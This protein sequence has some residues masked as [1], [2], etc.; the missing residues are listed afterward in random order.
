MGAVE[1]RRVTRRYETG[2]EAL[3]D[4]SLRI[5]AGSMAFL[6]GHSGAGKSTCLRLLLGLDRPTRGQ[7]L[8]NDVDVAA[9]PPRRLA[10]YRRQIG[11]VLQDPMLLPERTVFDNVAL[12]LRVAGVPA[13]DLPRRVRAALGL[14]DL[15][16]KEPCLPRELSAGEQ[17]R[18]GLA[19]AFVGRPQMLLADEPTGNLDPALSRD[20][21]DV[22]GRFHELGTTVIIATHEHALIARLGARIIELDHGAV[23]ADHDPSR[24][25]PLDHEALDHRAFNRSA[26]NEAAFSEAAFKQLSATE[27]SRP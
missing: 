8:V 2:Q 12:P 19:R 26:L 4:V 11:V 6:T 23:A 17:Q 15:Q 1:F 13:R 14:V 9:L 25:D 21:L 18:V 22:F 7:V 16:G 20:I 3:A 10:L 24:H 27:R 5:A